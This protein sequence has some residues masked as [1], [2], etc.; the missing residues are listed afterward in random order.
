MAEPSGRKGA[1]VPPAPKSRRGFE[2][3]EAIRV[4]EESVATELKHLKLSQNYQMNPSHV[5]V[6]TEKVNHRGSHETKVPHPAYADIT[7]KVQEHLQPSIQK[8]RFSETS[9]Q[10]V[11]WIVLKE[12]EKG[13]EWRPDGSTSGLR[14]PDSEQYW[15]VPRR[16]CDIT[17]TGELYFKQMHRNMFQKLDASAS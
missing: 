5:P 6:I 1:S 13:T 8:L 16:S 11:G 17:K 15:R 3:I 7:R 4:F 9:S 12:L 14:R 2:C 10:E